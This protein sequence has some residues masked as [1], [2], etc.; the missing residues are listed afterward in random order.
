MNS[1][2]TDT[3]LSTHNR[4]GSGGKVHF[5]STK[6]TAYGDPKSGLS[7][8][9][10]EQKQLADHNE[11]Q[12]T[13]GSLFYLR[14]RNVV[15]GSEKLRVEVR[16]KI[17][18][19]ILSRSD[20]A[21]GADY[22]IDYESGRIILS[23]P[24]SS[25]ASS[26]TV[27]NQAILDGHANVLVADYE[28][29]EAIVLGY[30]NSGLRGFQHFGDHFRV[31]G[32]YI[33]DKQPPNN[34]NY[35]LRG[36]DAQFKV[37]SH[38]KITAEYA[39]SENAQLQGYTSPNGGLSF[40][41]VESANLANPDQLRNGAYVIR[42]QSRPV[43]KL[44]VSVYAQ[45]YNPFFNN[46]DTVFSQSDY[47]KYGGEANYKVTENLTLRYRLDRLHLIKR[48]QFAAQVDRGEFQTIQAEYDGE[49]ILAIAEYRHSDVKVPEQTDRLVPSLFSVSDFNDAVGGKLGYRVTER[50]MPYVRG[51][52]TV[53]D[54]FKDGHQVGAGLEARVT[55]KSTVTVEENFGNIGDSTLLR[56]E[57][58]SAQNTTTY[59]T[60]AMGNEYGYGRGMRSTLGSS[61]ILDN[62]SRLFSEKQ[63]SEYRGENYARNIMGYERAFLDDRLGAVVTVERN[64][65]DRSREASVIFP[66]QLI[67]N[68]AFSTGLTY[69]EKDAVEATTRWEWRRFTGEGSSERQWL[70]Y[71]N[72]GIQL[73]EDVEFFGRFNFS[74]TRDLDFS[75]TLADFVELNAGFSFRPVDWDRF[76]ALTR[77]T[78]LKDN[79][80]DDR[81]GNGIALED[82]AH[83]V[84]MEGVY[85]L[86][87]YLALVEK[88]AFKMA[89]V[90]SS[91][92]SPVTA[93]TYLW[94]NRFN[95]HIT[96]KWDFAA[97]YRILTQQGAGEN[98]KHG[99]LVE[100]DREL[101]DYTR[102]GIGYNFTEFDDDLRKK[103][104]YQTM[105]RGPFVRLTGKF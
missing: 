91:F 84:A 93:Y 41:G 49:K 16:D 21:S 27:I 31:G 83:I 9:H 13:G 32:T 42:V 85:D 82:L 89:Q 59:A 45:K 103:N 19:V 15:E 48:E 36:V 86:S 65:L 12:G 99:V 81:F 102:V 73:T 75:N 78:F 104:S 43:K 67:L 87:R 94:I 105:S 20:L 7:A 37:S 50:Y 39:E 3:E 34:R 47:K 44:D 61:R 2:F 33:E 54:T 92:G 24:L 71:N 68:N 10:F 17:T 98:L 30:G 66:D 72:L 11:F 4:T 23:K 55:E 100:L 60:I 63:Y 28:Y 29:K 70:S 14:K 1:D 58:R 25:V 57:T 74:K 46:A 77:Y 35:T 56:F 5:E 40:S 6:S 90:D 18:G 97:E 79:L 62:R 88:V 101:F 53:N 26:D 8:F 22:E 38:T 64:E 52:A 76:N 80:P 69:K 95:F 96:R 51:Q